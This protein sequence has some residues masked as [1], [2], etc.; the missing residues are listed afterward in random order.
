MNIIDI[1]LFSWY[2]ILDNTIY[3]R[4]ASNQGISAKEHSFFIVFLLLGIN[5]YS[6][7]SY[8]FIRYFNFNINLY[9]ALINALFVFIVGYLIYFKNKRLNRVVTMHVSHLKKI[10]F[11]GISLI[12]TIASIYL[13]LRV[14][15][16]VRF[17]LGNG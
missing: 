10:L 12:Y 9:W 5:I 2:N 6:I 14:G 1:F 16:Y 17:K 4:S 7:F 13:M 3:S 15:D 8:L 11:I